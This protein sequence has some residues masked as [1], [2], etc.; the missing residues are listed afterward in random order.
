MSIHTLKLPAA[1]FHC[2]S[3]ATSQKIVQPGIQG[4]RHHLIKLFVAISPY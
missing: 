3:L 1:S 4:M 2:F